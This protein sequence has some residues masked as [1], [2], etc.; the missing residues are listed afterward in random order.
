MHRI[1]GLAIL[2]LSLFSVPVL[3]QEEPKTGNIEG[4]VIRADTEEPIANA[5]VTL[6]PILPLSGTG[7]TTVACGTV[8]RNDRATRV[9]DGNSGTIALVTT[10]ADGKFIFKEVN[11]MTYCVAATANGFVRQEY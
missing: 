10:G 9:V 8:I 4:I 2:A 3:P 7:A 6:T 11:P 5:Q 1:N